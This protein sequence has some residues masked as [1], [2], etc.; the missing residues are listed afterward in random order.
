MSRNLLDNLYVKIYAR[1]SEMDQN[2]KPQV[3]ASPQPNDFVENVKFTQ[4]LNPNKYDFE[5][6]EEEIYE[7]IRDGV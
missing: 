4:K 1:E 6:S 2:I 7:E 3:D 5:E